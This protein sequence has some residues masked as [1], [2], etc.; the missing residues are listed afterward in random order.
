MFSQDFDIA[1]C[2]IRSDNGIA[3]SFSCRLKKEK[4]VF[5]SC[6]QLLPFR[7]GGKHGMT[8]LEGGNLLHLCFGGCLLQA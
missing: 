8:R 1:F 5:Q 7:F 6:K 3:F 4:A 2:D